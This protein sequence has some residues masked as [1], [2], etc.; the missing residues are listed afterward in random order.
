MKLMIIITVEEVDN[1]LLFIIWKL[2]PS[3]VILNEMQNLL[4]EQCK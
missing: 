1:H 4:E 2:F 3:I